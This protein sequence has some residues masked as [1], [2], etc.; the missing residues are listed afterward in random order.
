MALGAIG[1]QFAVGYT[2]AFLVFQLGTLFTTGAFGEGFLPGL[3]AVLVMAAI[4][5]GISINTNKKI[6]AEYALNG[7]KSDRAKVNV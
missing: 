6:N 1:L 5:V 3:I 4:V 2:V 7:K